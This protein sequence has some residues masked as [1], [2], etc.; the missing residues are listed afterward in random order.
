VLYLEDRNWQFSVLHEPFE[1]EV[2]RDHLYLHAL[3]AWSDAD[4]STA[5]PVPP[6]HAQSRVA[7]FLANAA[8]DQIENGGITGEFWTRFNIYLDLRIRRGA[9]T[10]LLPIAIDPDVGH[11]GGTAP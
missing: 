9:D 4:G 11:P 6:V 8:Q 2:G 10:L 1:V 3:A 5:G 7:S